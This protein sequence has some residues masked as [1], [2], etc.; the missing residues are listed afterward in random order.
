[1]K[2]K[3]VIVLT[4][5]LSALMFVGCESEV[6][7]WQYPQSDGTVFIVEFLLDNTE[8]RA[9][10]SAAKTDAAHKHNGRLKE[11]GYLRG[12]NADAGTPWTLEQYI[13]AVMETRTNF[14]HNETDESDRTVTSIS[15]IMEVPND[16]GDD[17][18]DAPDN[19]DGEESNDGMTIEKGFFMYHIRVEQDGVFNS[20]KEQFYKSY[21]RG[22]GSN[23]DETDNSAMGVINNGLYE[24]FPLDKSAENYEEKKTELLEKGYVLKSESATTENYE[25]EIIPCFKDAFPNGAFTPST[26]KTSFIL[27]SNSKMK[28]SGQTLRDNQGNK[29]YLFDS[30]FDEKE[31]KIVYEYVRAN[32]VGWNV[33]AILLGLA[34]VGAI[35]LYCKFRKPKEPKK[36]A[37]AA[38]KE[39]FPYD[40]YETNNADPF[41]EYNGKNNDGNDNNPFAG[42]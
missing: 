8:M 42:Y 36:T 33:L 30:L 20:Y 34:T 10:D 19:A 6:Y 40:P 7:L 22:D 41:A 14:E 12:L 21:D 27:Q 32:S 31:D 1:M 25:I 5:I 4:L 3:I 39:R 24:I 38:A 28:T 23:R 11:M 15:F 26:L 29:Y 37:Y 17:E 2:K 18:D 35:L 16:V 9:L 13:T